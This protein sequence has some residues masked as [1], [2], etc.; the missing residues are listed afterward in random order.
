VPMQPKLKLK[1]SELQRVDATKYRSM[2]GSL[3]YLVNTR[4]NLAFF[5]GYVN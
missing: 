3:R 2:V 4:P 5:V 1:E